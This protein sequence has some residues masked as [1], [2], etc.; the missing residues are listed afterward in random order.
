[1][2]KIVTAV[3]FIFLGV[4]I[5]SFPSFDGVK[6]FAQNEINP[7]KVEIIFFY[8]ETCLHCQAEQKFLDTIQSKYPELEINR[9]LVSDSDSKKL[10]ADLLAKHDAQMYAGLVPIT[11]VGEDLILGF[12]NENDI[13]RRIEQS[14][15]RQLNDLNPPPEENNNKVSLPIIGKIDLTK[16]SLL[17]QAVILG[18]FDGFNVCSLGALVLIL[19][20]V[21]IL[22]SRPKI[23]LF[24]G[25]YILVTAIVYGVLIFLWYQLF[26]Y[27]APVLKI[28]NVFVGLLGI[29]GGIYF[30]RQFIKSRKS[31]IACDGKESKIV[32]KHSLKIQKA[33]QE[34]GGIWGLIIG[35]FIFAAVITIVEFPCSAVIPVL[36]AGIMA[37][38]KL[39]IAAYLLYLVIYLFF[40]MLDEIIVFLIAVFT[41]NIKLASGKVMTW[42]SLVEAIVLFGLGIY[43]L[44]SIF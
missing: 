31:D 32:S 17:V 34:S 25:L 22:R 16:Y 18:F 26:Y 1:M 11:F 2:K 20:L 43:Y 35:V 7:P 27:L 36:F 12:N 19:G 4:L 15:E 39:S 33:F 9:Y 3:F 29:A 28:M 8:S 14:I 38:A 10:L 40:Y 41:M 30:L 5:L 6:V 37:H 21:L 13:G 42:L 23:I 44:V 24:G